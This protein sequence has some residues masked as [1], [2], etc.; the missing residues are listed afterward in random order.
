MKSQLVDK[1]LPNHSAQRK[2]IAG[3]LHHWLQT[4]LDTLDSLQLTSPRENA[5]TNEWM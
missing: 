2:T 5:G 4:G 3:L 1:I